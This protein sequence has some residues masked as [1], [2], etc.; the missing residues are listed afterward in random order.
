MQ[1][2]LST[3]GLRKLLPALILATSVALA[4]CGGG[5]GSDNGDN[6]NDNTIIGKIVGTDGFGVPGATVTAVFTGNSTAGG[7]LVTTVT[8]GG[9][10][11][12][13]LFPG[14]Y[15]VSAFTTVGGVNYTGSTQAV[16]TSHSIISNAI[17]EM[18]P[19]NAQGIIQGYVTTGSGNPIPGV[20]VL[21][22]VNVEPAQGTNAT[23]DLLAVTDHNG[24]YKFPNVPTATV[25]YTLT[26][27]ALGF[28]NAT[29][30]VTTLTNGQTQARNLVLTGSGN[31][32]VPTPT[33]V[34]A[35]ALTQPS[36]VL[37]PSVIQAH[38]S[39]GSVYDKIRK[40][41]SPKYAQLAAS[42][43]LV[44]GTK[45][46]PHLGGF[47]AYAIE[48]DVF[49]DESNITNVSGYQISRSE[50]PQPLQA[51]DFLQDPQASLYVDLDPS[52]VPNTQ[53]DF[54]VTAVSV[55]NNSSSRSA[56]A[57]FDPLDLEVVTSPFQN[58][59]IHNPN[60]V[61]VS[62]QAVNGATQY[63]V[64]IYNEYPSVGATPVAS[65]TQL[66]TTSFN[67]GTLPAGNYWVLVSAADDSSIDVSISQ[68]IQFQVQ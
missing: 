32:T 53:Y 24:F 62:W 11:I 12:R 57:A 41:M 34:L 58:Q 64:F 51:Y 8:D 4:G 49:F 26:A 27:T 15:T 50:D 19:T 44:H 65:A 54:A 18:A 9:Y 29:T 45:V 14:I 28:V 21:A 56:A 6:T 33:N 1:Y 55:D 38:A 31:T 67:A 5:G 47:G 42:H 7:P 16:V 13:G 46:S 43:H 22:S 60:P 36:S 52:Y 48:A 61:T 68:I 3:A 20:R 10:R 40:I 37:T 25:P 59:T 2:R 23:S 30:T 63:G 66:T 17:I 35:A 39:I